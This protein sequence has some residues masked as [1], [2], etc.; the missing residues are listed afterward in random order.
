MFIAFLATLFGT[1]IAVLRQN[2]FVGAISSIIFIR[3]FSKWFQQDWTSSNSACQFIWL[4]LSFNSPAEYL[5]QFNI[6]IYRDVRI[7]MLHANLFFK[8]C[9][10]SKFSTF[11]LAE[12]APFKGWILVRVIRRWHEYFAPTYLLKKGRDECVLR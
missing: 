2:F 4:S 3:L 1:S 12:K 11:L 6:L 7:L 9:L 5:R 8:N 10:M